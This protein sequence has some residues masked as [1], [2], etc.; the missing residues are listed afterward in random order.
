MAALNF[1]VPFFF[2][3]GLSAGSF[4]YLVVAT[5]MHSLGADQATAEVVGGWTAF[6]TVIIVAALIGRKVASQQRTVTRPA[7]QHALLA[8]GNIAA[9][10]VLLVPGALALIV[11]PDYAHLWW[12]ALVVLPLSAVFWI[13]GMAFA[14]SR[15]SSREPSGGA[16]R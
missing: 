8:I 9:L 12:A 2:I 1:A 3:L 14:G 5:L 16:R 11:H 10:A 13:A 7:L 4:V 15:K 6:A